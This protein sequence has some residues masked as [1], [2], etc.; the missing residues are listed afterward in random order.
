MEQK[1]P[2]PTTEREREMQTA[3]IRP[4]DG[5]F[6]VRMN[7]VWGVYTDWEAVVGDLGRHFLK[8]RQEQ[9]AAKSPQKAA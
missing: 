3:K 9:R 1:I 8:H 6:A 7:G 2:A 4:M 5:G